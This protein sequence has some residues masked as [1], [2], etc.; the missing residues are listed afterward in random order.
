M[1]LRKDHLHERLACELW[2]SVV[3]LI[4]PG[5]SLPTGGQQFTMKTCSSLCDLLLFFYLSLFVLLHS[6]S[7][8]MFSYGFLGSIIDEGRSEL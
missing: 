8:S 4:S 1:N 7:P 6:E 2:V 5:V 3:H